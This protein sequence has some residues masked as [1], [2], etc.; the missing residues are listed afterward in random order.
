MSATAKRAL[1]IGLLTLPALWCLALVAWL[2]RLPSEEQ[3]IAAFATGL[4]SRTRAQ[5]HNVRLALSALDGQVIL[6]GKEF[7]FNRAVG[8]WTADQG[9]VRAPVSYAGEKT[10]DWGGGVCQ[11]STAL[12]NAA[13]LAGLPIRERHRHH[14]PTTYAPPGQDAAVAYPNIDLRIVNSLP[15]PVRISARISGDTI[16][17]ALRSRARSPHVFLDRVM[18]AMAEPATVVRPRRASTG[19]PPMKGQPGYEI[20]LY[21]VYPDDGGRRELVSRDQYPARNRVVWR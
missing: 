2:A 14:W 21:R 13:L 17:V 6:P 15:S 10:L 3:P 4:E 9:Y 19:R 5:I 7:S 8:S 11:A 18:M 20:A 1:L 16:V 12:Y